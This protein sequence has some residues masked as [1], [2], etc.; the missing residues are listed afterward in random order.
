MPRFVPVPTRLAV[1]HAHLDG[2]GTAEL[3]GRF[4]LPRRTVRHI[5]G[6]GRDSGGTFHGPAYASGPSASAFTATLRQRVLALRQQHP[7]WGA[8]LIR[9]CLED[10]PPDQLDEPVPSDS[11]IRR[12]LE[13]GGLSPCPAGRKAD[14]RLRACAAHEVW[15]VDA[16]DQMR[17]LG[18][19]LVSWLRLVDECSGAVLRTAVFPTVW[20]SVEPAATQRELRQAFCRWGLP[21]CLRFDNGFP[22][23]NWND[24]PTALALWL[25]GLGVGLIFNRPRHP[26]ENGVVER[27]HQTADAWVEPEACASAAELQCRLD[28][29]DAIQR[30][31]YPRVCGLSRWQLYPALR[32]GGRAYSE[33]WEQRN[34]SLEAARRYLGG[35]VAQRKVSS[36]GQAR[37]YAQRYYVGAMHK[38]EQTWVRYDAAANEWVFGD[39]QGCQ[40]CRKP[41]QQIN[42]AQIVGL[43]ISA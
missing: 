17:L 28:E 11:T 42:Q 20:N 14:S 5:I 36:Q 40:W 1:Y 22:W 19:S 8:T 18:G 25:T 35:H 24:L 6:Q 9:L 16:A 21:R 33:D 38:G 13:E 37:V 10:L 26:Q 31:R 3:A 2:L 4:N 39:E 29:M 43:A 41:A 32:Q 7:R 34:W 27:S 15:Q 12:W 30:E 23:G